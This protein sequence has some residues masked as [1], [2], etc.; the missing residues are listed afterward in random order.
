MKRSVILGLLLFVGVILS[1]SL[2]SAVVENCNNWVDD[3]GNG[4]IDYADSYCKPFCISPKVV[5]FI[6]GGIGDGN[7]GFITENYFALCCNKKECMGF[8]F[9]AK[10]GSVSGSAVCS[11][12]STKAVWCKK[13]FINDET[14]RCI[15]KSAPEKCY[16]FI[17]DNGDGKTDFVDATC[18]SK[19]LSF[20]KKVTYTEIGNGTGA[21]RGLIKDTKI[22]GCCLANECYIKGTGCVNDSTAVGNY[23]CSV[24][25]SSAV[26]CNSDH[27]H[28]NGL[29]FCVDLLDKWGIRYC[30]PRKCGLSIH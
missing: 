23:R 13:G 22:A 19:C 12:N 5:T 8:G 16:N 20:G 10:N 11:A 30:T 2:I 18:A 25:G 9:C 21:P 1:V 24:L 29:G 14:G 15:N 6:E 4:L 28:N 3:N 7:P 17:D 27:F 26:W